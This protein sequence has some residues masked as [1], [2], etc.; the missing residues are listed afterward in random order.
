MGPQVGGQSQK[1]SM[2]TPWGLK[3]EVR[4]GMQGLHGAHGQ[5]SEMGVETPS[6]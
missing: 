2:G 4:A 6:G 5:R 1:W 3:S